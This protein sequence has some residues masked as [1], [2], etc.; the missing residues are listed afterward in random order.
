MWRARKVD[1]AQDL[2]RKAL[3][4]AEDIPNPLPEASNDPQVAEAL[5]DEQLEVLTAPQAEAV[6]FTKP[7]GELVTFDPPEPQA[8]PPAANRRRAPR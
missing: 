5:T 2:P 8:A 6:T 3:A 4:G 1:H 7:P